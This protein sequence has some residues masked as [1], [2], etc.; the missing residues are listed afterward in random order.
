[1]YK[2][3]KAKERMP[4]RISAPTAMTMQR[5]EKFTD[6]PQLHDDAKEREVYRLP[7]AQ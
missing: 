7:I 5:R 4:G 6:C 3:L 2:C 1:M